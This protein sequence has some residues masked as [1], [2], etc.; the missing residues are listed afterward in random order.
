MDEAKILA[1]KVIFDHPVVRLVI[2]SV[3]FQEHKQ[4]YYYID[5]KINAVATLGL[6]E[7]NQVL[8]TRQYRHP[9]RKVI[10][11][12]PAGKLNPDE[13]PLQG[14]RRE[15]E[16]ET[17]YAPGEIFKL[18]MYN[19]FP[20]MLNAFTHLFFARNLVKTEQKLDE[21]EYL[22]VISLPVPELLQRVLAGEFIDGS[23]Q[24]A[25]LLAI[26]KGLISA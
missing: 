25:T 5:S 11:D 16:E 24:L 4:N 23:V 1:T 2:D 6:T 14:A 3:E 26:Q 19:Q 7:D 15:F 13:E 18:G 10:L 20:G 9:V 21:G 17:G 8:L 12:L 22:E